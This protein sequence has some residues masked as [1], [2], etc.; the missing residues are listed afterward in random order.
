[1]YLCLH[2]CMCAYDA[3]S[4]EV[5]RVGSGNQ[6]QVSYKSNVHS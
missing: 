3:D 5:P 4:C 2:V 6:T 1:M